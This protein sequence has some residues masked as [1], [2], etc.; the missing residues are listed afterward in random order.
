MTKMIV[1]YSLE[2]LIAAALIWYDQRLFF[3]YFFLITMIHL[4]RRVSHLEKMNRVVGFYQEARD[5]SVIRH[6][7][8]SDNALENMQK[9]MLK[10]MTPEQEKR[11]L[12]SCKD[13]LS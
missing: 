4:D 6:L 8:I 5:C 7:K 2:I 12:E 1:I 11:F 3:L 13:V 9:E 10:N